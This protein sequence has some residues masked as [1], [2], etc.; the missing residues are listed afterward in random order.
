MAAHAP[1]PHQQH[2]YVPVWFQERFL[3]P[4]QTTFKYLDLNPTVIVTPSGKSVRIKELQDLGPRRC[5]REQNLYT[6]WFGGQQ[7]DEIETK[8]FGEIDRIG[9]KAIRVLAENDVD[10]LHDLLWH[11]FE[12]LD[13][14]K[15]RTP[16]GLAWIK[17]LVPPATLKRHGNEIG[18][19][20][21]ILMQRAMDLNI[22]MWTEAVRE[23]V[24]AKNSPT[25]FLL[26]DHPV[27]TYNKA[28]YPGNKHCVYPNDPPISWIG[29]Q[30]VVPLDLEHLLVLTNLEYAQRPERDQTLTRNR[31]NARAYA[32]TLG[33]TDNTIIGRELTET[34]VFRINRILKTRAR[35]F[36]AA[37]DEEWL[38][39][40]RKD[41]RTPWPR[42][43]DALLPPRRDLL[44]YG[45]ETYVGGKNGE[46]LWY[47]DAYGRGVS[48]A[49][50]VE[51][52]VARQKDI[53]R[54]LDGALAKRGK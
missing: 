27:T 50:E 53:Q 43:G 12:F 40:E 41:P 28:A 23:I 29:S 5:F 51:R 33:R 18:S 3:P 26:T 24:S 19:Q 21:L 49:A 32:P 16:K 37:V 52:I 9:A 17:S 31:I 4:G 46:L 7:N 38:Y 15:I 45:G 54:V 39:P 42:L 48:G 47:Q 13:I 11:A 8:L 35:R 1:K 6:T 30:T 44:F 25:K 14:Q 2:H 34:D 20:A 10:A 36:I 22:T